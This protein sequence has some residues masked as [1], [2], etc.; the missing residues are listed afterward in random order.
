MMLQVAK[1]LSQHCDTRR[2]KPH[3]TSTII[4]KTARP[5]YER[6]KDIRSKVYACCILQ[7][8]EI[9]NKMNT[10][11][12][13]LLTNYHNLGNFGCRKFFFDVE[14]YENET[15]EI[16]STYVLCNW[17]RVKL[18]QITNIFNTNIL[19][20]YFL[21]LKFLQLQYEE[22]N[23]NENSTFFFPFLCLS[24]LFSHKHRR[25]LC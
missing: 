2:L 22:L 1:I 3:Q 9:C 25:L 14:E 6:Q 18:L 11:L 17:T 16:F 23:T 24:F 8:Q 10:P 19:H 4:R 15:Y 13:M 5:A 20:H 21:T 7:L 12:H